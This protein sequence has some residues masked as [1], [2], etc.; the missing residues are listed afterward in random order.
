[1]W[2]DYPV[3]K[4]HV[5]AWSSL[6]LRCGSAL[7]VPRAAASLAMLAFVSLSSLSG[8]IPLV[9]VAAVVL[10]LVLFEWL[11]AKVELAERAVQS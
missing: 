6:S 11:L 4:S 2:E 7:V 1:M 10:P 3:R 5:A 9:A 8:R